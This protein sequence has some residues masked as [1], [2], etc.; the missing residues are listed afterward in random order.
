MFLVSCFFLHEK[1][2]AKIKFFAYGTAVILVMIVLGYFLFMRFGKP[3]LFSRQYGGFAGKILNKINY[4]LS[5]LI[6][7]MRKT[8]S[9]ARLSGGLVFSALAM[10]CLY[11]FYW[12]IMQSAGIK[13]NY[14]EIIFLS[15]IMVPLILLP[16]KGIAGFGTQEAGWTVGFLILGFGKHIAILTGFAIHITTLVFTIILGVFGMAVIKKCFKG[17]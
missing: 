1:V 11:V 7:A 16:V 8:H 13:V 9:P 3:E 2:F 14:F 15:S 17:Q 5:E 12:L 6:Q 10:N 4:V